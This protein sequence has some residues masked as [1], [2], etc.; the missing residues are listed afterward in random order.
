MEISSPFFEW[1]LS[2]SLAPLISLKMTSYILM[3]SHS[4]MIESLVLFLIQERHD[5]KLGFLTIC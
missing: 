4:R 5:D 1:K 3:Q 2:V